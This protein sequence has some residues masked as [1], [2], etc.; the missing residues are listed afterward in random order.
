MPLLTRT[1]AAPGPMLTLQMLCN[2]FRWE[3]LKARL[4]AQLPQVLDLAADVAQSPVDKVCIVF[5]YAHTPAL[6]GA[7]A[8]W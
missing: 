2:C 1:T 4:A 3:P 8:R 7:I 6:T 5:V